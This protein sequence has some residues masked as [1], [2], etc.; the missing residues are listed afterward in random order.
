[1]CWN[2]RC[3]A[4][5]SPDFIARVRSTIAI[6]GNFVQKFEL[7]YSLYW[8]Q[9][10][11]YFQKFELL[12][13]KSFTISK[14]ELKVQTLIFK[15]KLHKIAIVRSQIA[16]NIITMLFAMNL[17]KGPLESP[18]SWKPWLHQ[19]RQES[20][21]KLLLWPACTLCVF[22]FSKTLCYIVIFSITIVV[23]G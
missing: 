20:S 12:K 1:M 2:L 18:F 13:I 23:T 5:Y 22:R 17:Q 16:E 10:C 19:I 9:F 14:S 11:S 3:P 4:P 15:R 6:F 21:L 8:P 7:Q